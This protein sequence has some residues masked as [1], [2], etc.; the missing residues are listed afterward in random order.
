VLTTQPTFTCSATSSS[1]PGTYPIVVSGAT[2]QNYNIT[3]VNGTLTIEER[4][5][6]PGDANSDESVDVADYS[7]I[8]NYI[9]GQ[10]PA[11][12]DEVAADVTQDGNVDV[13]DYTGVANIILFGNYQ[14]NQSN[15]VKAERINSCHAY[16]TIDDAGLVEGK[17]AVQVNDASEFAAVQ[18]DVRLPEGVAIVEAMMADGKQ[19]KNLGFAQMKDGTWRL[20]YGT[21]DNRNVCLVGN[22][23]LTL[24][25]TT[26]NANAH[27]DITIDNILLAESNS[28]THQLNSLHT[29]WTTGI[30]DIEVKGGTKVYDVM[31]RQWSENG[32]LPGG[33]YIVNGKK[34]IK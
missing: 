4:P 15:G 28:T 34:V 18:M 14:G 9:L 2:A 30:A 23:L 19:T 8:A 7:A 24:H 29:G 11:I 33:V 13:A 6:T 10:A 26:G 32:K 17:L 5:Y 21:L 12:F 16:M 20:L 31:G 3:F 22:T 27:G 1:T 25:L